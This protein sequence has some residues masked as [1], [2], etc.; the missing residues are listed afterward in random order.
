MCFKF[1]IIVAFSVKLLVNN[2][3]SSW[4]NRVG[5]ISCQF[6]IGERI[7]VTDWPN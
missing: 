4:C 3:C 2:N 6:G 7:F 5:D 1:L